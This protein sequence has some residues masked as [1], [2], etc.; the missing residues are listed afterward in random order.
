M[1]FLLA[2]ICSAMPARAAEVFNVKNYG[3]EGNGT[4]DDT[5]AIQSAI[6]A[7]EAKPGSTVEFPEG[8]YLYSSALQMSGIKLVGDTSAFLLAANS[9]AEVDVTGVASEIRTLYFISAVGQTGGVAIRVK[10]GASKFV[11]DH[12]RFGEGLD[13]GALGFQRD[14]DVEGASGGTISGN[15]FQVLTRVHRGVGIRIEQGAN[16]IEVNQNTFLGTTVAS[17]G[18]SRGLEID[19]CSGI[20]VL[21]N[22]FEML[23]EATGVIESLQ[24]KLEGNGFTNVRVGLLGRQNHLETVELNSFSPGSDGTGIIDLF[25][26]D[27]VIEDNV[28]GNARDGLFIAHAS[29]LQVLRNKVLTVTGTAMS[30]GASDQAQLQGNTL[31]SA[32]QGIYLFDSS[33]ISASDNHLSK[34]QS[35]A[36]Q[37]TAATGGTTTLTNNDI[38][39]AG[40]S[41]AAPTPAAVIYINSPAADAVIT[42]NSYRGST[43]NLQYYI[44]CVQGPPKAT[45][46]G[47][48]TNTLL[49]NR[50][51]S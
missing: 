23:S 41:L 8:D 27:Q 36:I 15:F 13:Q 43:A 51:G 29:K 17:P 49:P 12:N 14:I 30:V 42:E 46:L 24:V 11:L 7:A 20:K 38:S 6:N 34:I 47:N 21:N 18:D 10:S 37:S 22:G 48:K 45:V 16:D 4:H 33:N 9:N 25:G 5:T 50:I 3:A 44:W 1:L 28:I 39:D 26:T 35:I 2:T 31:T 19:S 32:A 40:L